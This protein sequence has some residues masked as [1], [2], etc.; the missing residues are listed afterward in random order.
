MYILPFAVVTPVHGVPPAAACV[1]RFR[2]ELVL[3]S[4]GFAGLKKMWTV[5]VRCA[6]H[7]SRDNIYIFE[8]QLTD[9][10]WSSWILCPSHLHSFLFR[11][12][13]RTMT[14]A[15]LSRN[16]ALAHLI[17]FGACVGVIANTF[18]GDGNPIVASLAFSGVAFSSTYCLIRWLGNAFM[19][20][21][22]KGKDM[23]KLRQV[24]LSVRIRVLQRNGTLSL[25]LI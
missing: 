3:V 7:G 1:D 19:K 20:A 21:G 23:S 18:Q 9:N 12:L 16:E 11:L 10:G 2:A 22:F 5:C 15:S 13:A 17:L 6:A 25:R 24:E 4:V 8:L 14:V